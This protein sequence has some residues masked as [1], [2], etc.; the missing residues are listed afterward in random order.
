MREIELTQMEMTF[1]EWCEGLDE[2]TWEMARTEYIDL[3]PDLCLAMFRAD[4]SP[5]IAATRA[6]MFAGILTS[7]GALYVG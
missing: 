6:L 1:A 7:A 2:A 5:R 3:D 4:V